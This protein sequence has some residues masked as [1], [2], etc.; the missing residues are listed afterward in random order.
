MGFGNWGHGTPPEYVGGFNPVMSS[1]GTTRA[2]F[3][4]SVSISGNYA[5]VGA[6]AE[7][8][9]KNQDQGAAYIYYF[10]GTVWEQQQKLIAADGADSARFGYSVSISGNYAIVGAPLATVGGSIDRGA[11]YIYFF[12]GASWV[13]Q[14]QLVASN[15]AAGDEFG[16]SV[17]ISGNRAIAGAIYDDVG[18]NTNQGSAYIYSF[19][20]ISW[21]LQ[22]QL[23]TGAPND[24]FGCSVGISGNKVIIGANRADVNG[25]QDFGAAYMYVF[26]SGTWF[27]LQT[28]TS[29]NSGVT[30]QDP[31]HEFGTS[32]SI[33]GNAAIAGGIRIARNGGAYVYRF[34]GI[35]WESSPLLQASD[36]ALGDIFGYSVSISGDYAVVGALADA[37][38]MNNRQGSAYVFVNG[39]GGWEQ[40][41]KISDPMGKAD[42]TFGTSC[43]ID[44]GRL[45]VGAMGA[46]SSKGVCYFG[47][48]NY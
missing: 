10:N 39:N 11:A 20:D 43:S 36:G 12:N 22:T 35:Q 46:S 16:Y 14:Q 7:D 18:S 33:S 41:Q 21:S 45:A 17:G 3:G 48:I 40:V 42:D 4:Q 5:I 27:H 44:N 28:L 1:D 13:Q 38:G 47:K 25:L 34:S 26:T 30:D 37:I 9:G 8:V 6:F 32:V 2:A 15:G 31:P 19:N 23:T 24:H 29:Y